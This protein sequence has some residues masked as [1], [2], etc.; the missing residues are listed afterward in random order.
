MNANTLTLIRPDDWHV[1]LRDGDALK[2]V[3]P[4]TA[5]SFGRAVVMPNLRPPVTTAAQALAYRER[6]LAEV[7]TGVSFDPLMTLYLTDQLPPEE[8]QRAKAAGVV[9]CKL[10]PAGATTNSDSGVTTSARFTPLWRPCS[11]RACCSWCTAR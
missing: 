9:A 6:I 7:P 10:Y 4:H 2:T 11:A 3:V 5:V 1:H 8:I